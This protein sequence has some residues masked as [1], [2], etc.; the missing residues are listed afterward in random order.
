MT[1]T[2]YTTESNTQLPAR[3]SSTQVATF[4]N[5]KE[6][7]V[8]IL[9][10]AGLLKPLGKP[11]VGCEKYFARIHIERLAVDEVWLN[12]ATQELYDSFRK[13]NR[14]SKKGNG[15]PEDVPPS[16]MESEES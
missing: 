10:R 1:T 7:H 2:T 4:L 16:E 6:A 3:L 8:P 5:L 9:V 11:V 14:K 15:T 13:K 12:R